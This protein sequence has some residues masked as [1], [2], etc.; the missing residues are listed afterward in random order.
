MSCSSSSSKNFSADHE[1]K[2]KK[3]SSSSSSKV[4]KLFGF[5][6]TS[7]DIQMPVNNTTIR[8]KPELPCSNNN[9]NSYNYNYYNMSK[10]LSSRFKC[11]YCYQEFATSQALGGHQNAHKSERKVAKLRAQFQLGH[12]NY[13]VNN[14]PYQNPYYF[15]ASNYSTTST[16]QI[17]AVQAA[18]GSSLATSTSGVGA[19]AAAG[20]EVKPMTENVDMSDHDHEYPKV[21]YNKG[22][23]HGELGINYHDQGSDDLDLQLRL[24]PSNNLLD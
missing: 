7:R 19:G 21:S 3:P 16:G 6:V 17:I 13:N 22:V 14:N 9:S 8:P 1:G 18:A 24:A 5:P 11:E 2:K 12:P 23:C 15:V 4:F 20:G 10:R